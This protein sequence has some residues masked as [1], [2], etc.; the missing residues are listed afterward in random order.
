MKKKKVLLKY[1]YHKCNSE[2]KIL[3]IIFKQW[4]QFYSNILK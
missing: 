3:H 1:V 2:L 4:I